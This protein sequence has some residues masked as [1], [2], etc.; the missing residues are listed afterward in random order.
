MN[1]T[2]DVSTSRVFQRG[3]GVGSGWR[4]GTVHRISR[5]VLLACAAGSPV[6]TS[7]DGTARSDFRWSN[8]EFSF[9]IVED[10]VI[11]IQPL[12]IR[13]GVR[14][15]TDRELPRPWIMPGSPLVSLDILDQTGVHPPV[16]LPQFEVVPGG[17]FA[18]RL[19]PRQESRL[20]TD[21]G[22]FVWGFTDESAYPSFWGK[23]WIMTLHFDESLLG[24][25]AGPAPRP[26]ADTLLVDAPTGPDVQATTLFLKST[27]KLREH[28]FIE[29]AALAEEIVRLSP[30]SRLSARAYRRLLSLAT[31]VSGAAGRGD[32]IQKLAFEF[33]RKRPDAPD[34]IIFSEDLSSLDSGRVYRRFLDSVR[35]RCPSSPILIQEAWGR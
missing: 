23:R 28:D 27:R 33:L 30:G 29:S 34:L 24:P 4:A 18:G 32:Y 6:L 31:N 8:Y 35:V 2:G 16:S 13:V 15:L 19:A 14:N 26:I 25:E 22:T 12:W 3:R 1:R 20:F 17:E 9:S 5:F 10:T 7:A 11:P 21:L